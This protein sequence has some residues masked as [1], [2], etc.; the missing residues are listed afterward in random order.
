MG[1][2]KGAL[3]PFALIPL[4]LRTYNTALV[5]TTLHFHYSIIPFTCHTCC[6]KYGFME[7]LLDNRSPDDL[8]M[9][10]DY[11]GRTPSLNPLTDSDEDLD[12]WG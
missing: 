12:L 6:E 8:E 1:Y 7:F 11:T 3:S 5:A 4:F 10:L 2:R 9:S